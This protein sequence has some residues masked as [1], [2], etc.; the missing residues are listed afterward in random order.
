MHAAAPI[1]LQHSVSREDGNSLADR[2]HAKVTTL[3]GE[4]TASIADATQDALPTGT[5]ARA[6]AI[7]LPVI[8][9]IALPTAQPI[10]HHPANLTNTI[11]TKNPIGTP[12]I[13]LRLS[14]LIALRQAHSLKVTSLQKVSLMGR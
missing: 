8:L 6:L 10:A 12:R 2:L 3:H 5:A 14:L 11:T 4:A 13:V 9:P 1:T 7:T